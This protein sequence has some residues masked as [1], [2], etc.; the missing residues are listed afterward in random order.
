MVEVNEHE[1]SGFSAETFEEESV[2]SDSES[3]IEPYRL[4]PCFQP[5][6]SI[7][8]KCVCGVE[9]LTRGLNTATGETTSPQ[10][11][12]D[13]SRQHGI[14]VELD[15]ACRDSII[16]S[17]STFYQRNRDT[18]LFLNLQSSILD[19]VGGSNHLIDTVR[20][21]RIRPS[22]IV[23][24]INES[25]VQDTFLLKKF[26]DTYRRYGFLIALDD[27]GCGFSNLDRISIV[28]PDIIKADMS[29]TRN[30]C[31][32]FYVRE[33]FRFLVKLAS[34]IGAL[35]VAEG[36]ETEEES[37]QT[38]ELGAHL[39]QGY[40]LS[41]PQS[42]AD[43]VAAPVLQRI[44]SV[45]ARFRQE[46]YGKSRMA[47]H[48]FEEM[49]S[50]TR[51][52]T[53]RLGLL[54]AADFTGVL[55]REVS[56]TAAVECAYL[57]DAQGIQVSPTVFSASMPAVK[58]SKLIFPA[59]PGADHSLKTYYRCLVDSGVEKCLTESYVSLAT[60]SRCVTFS[61]SFRDRRE[62]QFILCVDFKADG[63]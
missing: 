12:F 16:G 38:L 26:V 61:R 24:E 1:Y 14:Q 20:Y 22:D 52:I 33:V 4:K 2:W 35:V 63:G 62:N 9:G 59:R 47:K 48:R 17:F 5:I 28:K 21:Y 57:L 39:L 36:V 46:E 56:D 27:V 8:K 3:L 41:R 18:L 44:D 25:Q 45:A 30:I 54:S 53:A 32:D 34:N 42:L 51:G 37:V 10:E 50:L 19:K 11:L 29:L 15:R 6:V 60:G 49:D 43:A 7:V 23:I 31:T 40:C 58:E 13:I 55:R